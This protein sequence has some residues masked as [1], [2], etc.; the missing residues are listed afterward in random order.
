MHNKLAKHTSIR[1]HSLMIKKAFACTMAMDIV[2]ELQ[3]DLCYDIYLCC[4]YT[5]SPF[6]LSGC[7]DVIN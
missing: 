7:H 2:T 6:R 4:L 3:Y 1:I 5:R